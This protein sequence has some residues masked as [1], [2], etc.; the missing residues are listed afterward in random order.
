LIATDHLHLVPHTGDQ[1][2]ALIEQP[3][4][5]AQLSGYTAATGLR[6]F[7][8]SDEVSE[9][10]LTS[11]RTLHDSDPWRF[12]FA[13]VDP[14][15]GSVIGSG[16]FKGPPDSAGMVEIAYGIVPEFQ[17]RGYATEVARALVGYALESGLVRTV[18]AHTL[19]SPNASTKVLRKCGFEF[20]G[21]VIEPDDGLVWRWEL[22][23]PELEGRDLQT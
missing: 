12:G 11:L 8:V 5:Y 2:L 21:E 3:D 13:V 7:F 14:G 22:P 19:P 18:R 1:L 16:G 10:F 23:A 4:R 9:R 20:T 17:G 15:S 6:E